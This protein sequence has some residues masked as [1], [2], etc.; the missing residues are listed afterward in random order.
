MMKRRSFMQLVAATGV[1]AMSGVSLGGCAESHLGTSGGTASAE[2]GSL[3][4][5]FDSLGRTFEL[6]RTAGIVRVASAEASRVIGM[7]RFAS[8]RALAV[9]EQGRIALV[10]VAQHSVTVF[11]AALDPLFVLRTETLRT[12]TGVAFAQDGTLLVADGAA[13]VVR[14]Y[15]WRGTEL[16]SWGELG[17]DLGQLN[18]PRAIAIAP[19]GDV[20]VAE[21]GNRRVQVFTADGLATGTYGDFAAVALAFDGSGRSWVADR[22]AGDVRIFDRGSLVDGYVPDHGAPYALSTRADGSVYVAAI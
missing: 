2:A 17:S 10:D 11:D 5:V 6:D 3:H 15:D 21:A 7:E 19:D 16:G 14:R 8:P 20:H 13:H 22:I 12:P 1:S 18:Y 4:L 9:D